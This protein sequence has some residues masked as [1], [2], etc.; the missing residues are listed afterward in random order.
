MGGSERGEAGEIAQEGRESQRNIVMGRMGIFSKANIVVP[1][2]A[3]AMWAHRG[4]MELLMELLWNYLGAA[5]VTGAGRKVR[6]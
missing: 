2:R 6:R 1:K 3:A 4:T 5:V